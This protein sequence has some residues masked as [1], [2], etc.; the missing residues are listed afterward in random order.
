MLHRI[1]RLPRRIQTIEDLRDHLQVAIELEHSTIPAYLCALY[2]IHED[3][4]PEARRVLGGI[5]T[6]EMFH[7]GLAANVLLSIGG[8]PCMNHPDFLPIYPAPLPH[9]E[10][11]F[12]VHLERFSPR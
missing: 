11:H 1:H 9:S 2:S 4:N 6:E 7:M 10:G 3:A 8:Q 12:E 5:V